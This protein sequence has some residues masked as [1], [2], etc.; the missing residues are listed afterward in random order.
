MDPRLRKVYSKCITEIARGT[1]PDLVNDLYDYLMIDLASITY[2]LKDPRAFLVNVR[3]AID[4]GYL[5][6]SVVFVVDYSKPEHRAVAESRV[7]WLRDL[8]LDFIFAKD[9]PAEIK[10]AKECLNKPRCIVLS[11]DYDPLIIMSEMIQPIKITERAW[12][13][14]RITINRECV[15]KYLNE[16]KTT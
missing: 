14:R 2:G 5:K 9:E 7:K 16:D 4:Y 6:P 8:S 12:I 1:L 10:A 15:N 3:L 11:R 13:N